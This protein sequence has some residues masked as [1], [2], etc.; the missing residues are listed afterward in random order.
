M[1][2]TPLLGEEQFPVPLP[3]VP[4]GGRLTQFLHHWE[5]FTTDVWV[6]SVIRGGLD[7]V[8][9]ERPPL[10]DSPIPMSQTSDNKKFRLL[11]E[12]VQPLLL[13]RVIEE[14][15]PT[16]STPGFYS[17]LFLVPK[18]TGGMRPVIDLSILNSY[19]S[20]PHFK[21]ETNRSIR[22]CILPGML[23]TKLDLSDAYFHIPIS[24]ASRKFLRFVWNNK[25][26][27]FLAVPFGL[28]VAP[29]VFTRVFQT[30]IAHLHTLSIQ[31]HSYLNDSL[32]KEFDSEILSRHTFLFIRLLLDLGFLISWK[33]S[34]ILPSQDF[35]FLGEHYRTDLGLIFPPEEKF[36]SLCQKILIFSNSPSVTARQFSQLLGF[37]NSLADVVPLGRLH[38]RP[39]QFFLQGH[40]DSA[41]QVW[42]ALVPILPVLLPH[43]DWWTRRENVL[44]GVALL[45]P[46]PSLTLYTDSSLQGW[47]AFLEGKS[48]SGVWSLVQQQEHI[49]LLEMRAVLLAL[50]HFKTLLV[51]KAVVLATDN[52]TV[53]A[54]LQNQGG[55]RC[56][57]LFLLC[58]EILLLCLLSHIH[59]VV[60][61]IPGTF[62][63]LADC[64]S[65]FHNPV[66]TEWELRQ[67]V[68]DSVV[69]RWDRPHVDLFATSLNHKL[70]TFVS[71]VPDPLSFAVDAMSLS[72]DGMFAYAVSSVPLSSSSASQDQAIRLQDHYYCTSLAKTSM[73]SRTSAS[74]LF[75]AS[76]TS[77]QTRSSVSVQG[78][79]GT[80][81]A[82][83]SSSSRLATLREGLRQKG[84]SEGATSHISKSVRQSTGIVYEAKW[85]IFCDWCSGRDIDPVRVTVQQLADFLVYIFEIKRLVP[86]TNKGYRSAIGRT[87]SLLGGPDFGQNEYISLLVR[88]FRLERP[89]QNKL[90]PQWNL[91]LVLA[92]LLNQ[93]R[94]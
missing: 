72:W 31:A 77:V 22:A 87:I 6:L 16:Q 34:Q 19:L 47:G 60:R 42:E 84:F 64:L 86:S 11:S 48:V 23:T 63:V 50:Q 70:E 59:L 3:S 5:K 39:L 58:K 65:R 36:Q 91:G 89:K 35:L 27:Q 53:V 57:T 43:L 71:P 79:S 38:I 46:V 83:V 21:M 12:E 69:L 41:S 32:L 44:T 74:V 17:R 61:H 67:V 85:A 93:Q 54:Y 26:Y 76:E 15:P 8:F 28:A 52:T 92:A 4:V 82:R 80:S 55:T 24:L 90:V 75:Q 30:V 18:K 20:V 1:L 25:V 68:F 29:Q 56:Y 66:N 45:H 81:K 78:K 88:S 7:L 62:N 49:N 94:K 14:I 33:R 10:S 37:L 9:Q 51:S 73:V 40:W 13:K 2:L